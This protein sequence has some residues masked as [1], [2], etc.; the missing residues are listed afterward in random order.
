MFRKRRE[1]V[2]ETRKR[3]PSWGQPAPCPGCD[4]LG[5][6]L[7]VDPVHVVMQL[8]CRRCGAEWHLGE[9]DVENPPDSVQRARARALKAEEE[10]VRNARLVAAGAEA[11]WQAL[12][13]KVEAEG[14]EEPR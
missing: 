9:A 8:K 4:A 14:I 11:D 2:T 12:R 5:V 6:L 3:R 1:P 7:H 10:R 13:E